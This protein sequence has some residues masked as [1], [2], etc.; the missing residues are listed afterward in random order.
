MR[1]Q[2]MTNP[3]SGKLL[4]SNSAN[5]FKPWLMLSVI[6]VVVFYVK[7]HAAWLQNYPAHWVLPLAEW[8]NGG[9]E[10]LTTT[11]KPLSRIISA[12]LEWPMILLRD[13]LQWIP[14]PVSVLGIALIALHVAGRR[15]AI[16]CVLALVYIALS[17][18]WR[19]AMNTMALVGIAVVLALILGLLIGIA[20]NRTK[21]GARVVPFVLDVM[22]T[23][24]TFA[25][26]IPLLVI[27]GFGPV[28]GLIASAIY[29]CPPMVRN[30][31]LGLQRVSNEVVEAATIAGS[32]SLQQLIWVELPAALT[33]IKVGINQ[34][35][36]ATLSMVI[37]ASV[38]GGFDDIGW[39]VLSTMRKA[40]FGESLMAGSIIVLIAIIMDRI[41]AA[42]AS[43]DVHDKAN[44]FTRQQALLAVVVLGGLCLLLKLTQLSTA[45]DTPE[46]ARNATQFLDT[47]LNNLVVTFGN[48]L[49]DIKNNFFYYYLLPLRIGFS[50]SIM[51]F[52]WGFEF[53][54][55]MRTL[56]ALISAGLAT[57]LLFV[58]SW[59]HALGF[60][61]VMYILYFGITGAPWLVLMGA[62]S[63]LGYQLGGIRL[64]VFTLVSLLFILLT[65]MWGRAMLS[66]YLCGAAV[67]FAFVF[68]SLLGVW[69]ASSDKV[70]AVIR[71]IAETFQTIPPFVFL[72]PVLMFFQVGEFTAL[73]AIVAYAFVP[74][75]RYTESGL[76]QVSP[77]LLEVATAQGCTPWQLFWQV[78]LPLAMPSILVGLNQTVMFAFAMLVIAAL[79]GTT[80]LGQQIFLALG[81]A[82]TGLGV[83][84]GLSMALLAMITDRMLQAWAKHRFG[85]L[86]AA[87]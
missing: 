17:G 76:R 50:Q 67:V 63:L 47:K 15:L 66:V 54:P 13:T 80:G 24:P 6:A 48:Q 46:W 45:I 52:T 14:W 29:A 21:L 37:I 4:G 73:L 19:Q 44:G 62:L 40:R 65:G 34:T 38:I 79:V 32:S 70:S 2:S 55:Q 85:E 11:I 87:T 72:I 39:E 69:A 64:G 81:S 43:R 5:S 58:K 22:Q 51:E 8:I 10:V 41:S 84:A 60:A 28:V 7:D 9:M 77:Q 59:R 35:I 82:D 31:N 27:F 74:A 42:Y 3:A 71:P 49:T 33:Q 53:T 83:I 18:Y 78:R 86:P 68:G 12:S 57:M 30:V 25:Y 61:S 56:Y 1:S 36:M 75:A 16:A 23:M 26:L 20:A